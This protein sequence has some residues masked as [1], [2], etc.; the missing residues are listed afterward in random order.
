MGVVYFVI[1]PKVCETLSVGCKRTEATML[2]GA[3]AR[4]AT[5]GKTALQPGKGPRGFT[6]VSPVRDKTAFP[7]CYGND[8]FP[9]IHQR[10]AGPD[11]GFLPQG[12]FFIAIPSFL[13][14][15]K[16]GRNSNKSFSFV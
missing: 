12:V 14:N 16:E 6:E 11:S 15:L 1:Y 4:D 3:L 13:G 2:P 10:P 8:S 5:E 7:K 9:N